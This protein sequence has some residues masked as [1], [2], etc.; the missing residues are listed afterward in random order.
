MYPLS[1]QT[2][3]TVQILSP[4]GEEKGWEGRG[5]EGRGAYGLDMRQCTASS[6]HMAYT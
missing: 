4:Q 6:E 3:I 1:L 2:N 5:E